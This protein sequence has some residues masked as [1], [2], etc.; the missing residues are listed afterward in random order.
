MLIFVF[1]HTQIVSDVTELGLH[2]AI[3]ADWYSVQQ[4][5]TIKFFDENTH[6]W[7]FPETGGAHVP[8]LNRLLHHWG[9]QL[10]PGAYSGDFSLAGHAA[11]F[12]SGSIVLPPPD[13][14]VL[15]AI[16][17]NDNRGEAF[18]PGLIPGR[19][20]TTALGAVA[21]SAARGKGRVTV[22][23]DS[24]C[25]DD[26]ARVEPERRC[27]WLV[28]MMLEGQVPWDTVGGGNGNVPLGVDANQLPAES[29]L[30]LYSRVL[31]NTTHRHIMPQCRRVAW[32]RASLQRSDSWRQFVRPTAGSDPD[33]QSDLENVAVGGNASLMVLAGVGAVACLLLVVYFKM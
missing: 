33:T 23:G 21:A 13:A 18:G 15:S 25:I 10:S 3:F 14:A 19:G 11:A 24:A 12:V 22:Y 32:V 6:S 9:F 29:T 17:T 16:V 5:R 27:D 2:V 28:T 8:A 30:H 26:A 31:F 4:M 1:S 20:G 7:W